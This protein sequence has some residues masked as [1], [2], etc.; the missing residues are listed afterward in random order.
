MFESIVSIVWS[1][2]DDP[3]G[4]IAHIAEHGLEME[5]VEEVLAN[6]LFETTSRTSGRPVRY[7]FTRERCVKVVFEWMDPGVAYPIT[8][9]E[10]DSP[11][12]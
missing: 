11:T 1:L 5:E 4:N 2:E 3:D 7:G 9:Y 6:P 10:V 12:D 8:A